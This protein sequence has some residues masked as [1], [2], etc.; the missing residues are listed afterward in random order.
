MMRIPRVLG[1]AGAIVLSASVGGAPA[2]ARG[3]AEAA[4]GPAVDFARDV[5]PILAVSCVRCHGPR[6]T[7][8]ELRLDT[9]EGLLKGGDSGAVVVP[10]DGKGSLF[11]QLL[12]ETEQGLLHASDMQDEPLPWGPKGTARL[13]GDG[14]TAR[15]R[16]A[17]GRP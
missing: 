11:Y 13:L 1:P 9:R 14:A 4:P 5:Q 15:T 16:R 8:G 2:S 17:P 10:G 6:K 3:P 12:I 7:E